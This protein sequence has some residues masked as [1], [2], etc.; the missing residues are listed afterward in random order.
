MSVGLGQVVGAYAGYKQGVADSAAYRYQA[1]VARINAALVN[2]QIRFVKEQSEVAKENVEL[3]GAVTAG[4]GIAGYAAGNVQVRTGSALTWEMSVQDAIERQQQAIE[5]EFRGQKQA[6]EFEQL[7]L[8]Q[9]AE[10]LEE[11][12]QNARRIAAIGAIGGAISGGGRA[13]GEAKQYGWV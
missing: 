7:S 2:E 8:L 4:A 13:Y 11:S 9:S 10:N 12:A 3:E 6:A 5:K 1:N